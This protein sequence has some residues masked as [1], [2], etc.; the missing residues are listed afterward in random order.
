MDLLLEEP[1]I[2]LLIIHLWFEEKRC[3]LCLIQIYSEDKGTNKY[4]IIDCLRATESIQNFL[5]F[6]KHQI[7]VVSSA[8]I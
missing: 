2:A 1:R 6:D 4:I 3:V 8:K 5:S 7:E